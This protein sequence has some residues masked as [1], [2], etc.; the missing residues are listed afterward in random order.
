MWRRPQ[1][2]ARQAGIDDARGNLLPEDKLAAIEDL[3]K[4]YGR[5]AMTGDGINDAPALGAPTSA[6][7]WALPAPTR[8]WKR[9]TW[10]S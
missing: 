6:S 3:Q 10:S 1:T 8:P 9:P 2:I 4:R 7:P 5:T